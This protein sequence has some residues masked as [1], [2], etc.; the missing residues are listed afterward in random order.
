MD[1]FEQVTTKALA[2]PTENRAKLAELL[3][4]S[5]EE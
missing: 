1:E 5:L 3:I 2:L 4:Q